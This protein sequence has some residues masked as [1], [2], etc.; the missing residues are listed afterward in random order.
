MGFRS[1]KKKWQ[2]FLKIK[3]ISSEH[4]NVTSYIWRVKYMSMVAQLHLQM[5]EIFVE[6]SSHIDIQCCFPRLH[7]FGFKPTV[8]SALADLFLKSFEIYRS[9]VQ[10]MGIEKKGVPSFVKEKKDFPRWIERRRFIKALIFLFC[11]DLGA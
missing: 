10:I 6:W 5:F 2:I 4:I 11:W 9:A 8:Y 3:S 1:L 7:F